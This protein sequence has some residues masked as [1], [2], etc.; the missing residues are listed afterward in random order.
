[1]NIDIY[2]YRMKFIIV[3]DSNTGKTSYVNRFINNNFSDKNESTI[4]V[5][6]TSTN[7]IINNKRIIM[8]FW[9]TAGQENFFSLTANYFRLSTGVLIFFDINNINS[10]NNIRKWYDRATTLCSK[11]VEI[12]LLGTNIDR[13]GENKI[14]DEDIKNLVKQLEITYFPISSKTN[15][16]IRESMYFLL[17][18]IVNKIDFNNIHNYKE[19]GITEIK[20]NNNNYIINNSCCNVL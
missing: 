18:K 13:A 7:R 3:G 8:N 1:M 10:F 16:N 19:I 20:I 14:S 15:I 4:G 5:D 17:N 6:F 11:N 9:D 2:G 12:I